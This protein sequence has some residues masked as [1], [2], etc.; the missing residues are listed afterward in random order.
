MV[1]LK[2]FFQ[3]V[4]FEENQQTTKKAVCNELKKTTENITLHPGL[5]M[6]NIETG[7]YMACCKSV[8]K[9]FLII[10][11]KVVLF[12]ISS[13]GTSHYSQIEIP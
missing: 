5:K 2:E 9:K 12:S 1:F 11:N 8:T 10:I 6:L 7:D 4:N 3:I 13:V